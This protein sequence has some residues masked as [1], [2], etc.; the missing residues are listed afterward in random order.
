MPH[1]LPFRSHW[2]EPCYLDTSKKETGKYNISAGS[3]VIPNK[4]D[5]ITKKET[6]SMI[7][8]LATST[9]ADTNAW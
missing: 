3:T 7:G 4:T 1:N 2:A 5:S 8:Q 9:A 6:M